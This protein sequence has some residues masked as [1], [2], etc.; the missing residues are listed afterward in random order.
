MKDELKITKRR[1]GGT[2]FRTSVLEAGREGSPVLI[3]LHDGALG[4]CA[5]TTWRDVI[6]QLSSD[7]HIFA[8]DFFG[9]GE[10]NMLFEFGRS[11][12]ECH[13]DQIA[14]LSAELGL[15]DVHVIGASY[16]GSVM[17][18]ALAQAP[19]SWPIRSGISISGAGGI[20]RHESGKELLAATKPTLESIRACMRLLVNEAWAGLDENAQRRCDCAARPGHWEALYSPRLKCPVPRGDPRP[21][22]AYPASLAACTVPVLLVEG[23]TDVLLEEGWGAQ[24]A[25]LCSKFSVVRVEAGHSPNL[26]HPGLIAGIVRNFVRDQLARS[27]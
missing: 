12:Y 20:F 21:P 23:A 14:D 6:P 26:D 9:F 3:L 16:G 2:R 24:L 15:T 4:G 17:M 25:R 18:R 1:I 8:P 13:I 11:P 19:L 10:S 7:F 22:D 5:E 27:A